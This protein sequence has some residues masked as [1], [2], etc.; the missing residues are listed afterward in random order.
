MADRLRKAIATAR[1][2]SLQE[3]KDISTDLKRLWTRLACGSQLYHLTK[4]Y[5][6]KRFSR[7]WHKLAAVKGTRK[8]TFMKELGSGSG[9]IYSNA[10]KA[11]QRGM[12]W[13]KLCDIFEG[14]FKGNKFVALCT[15]TDSYCTCIIIPQ[16]GLDINFNI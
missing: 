3:K 10:V 8:T 1:I 15:Y 5:I 16:D 4:I 11:A 9:T 13:V 14:D 2:D 6:H 7:K 12:V